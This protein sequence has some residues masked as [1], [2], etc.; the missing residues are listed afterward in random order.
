M[1]AFLNILEKHEIERTAL[2]RGKLTTL[3]V[4]MGDLCNQS[5]AHCHIEASPKGKKIMPRKVVDDILTFLKANKIKT[6]DIT[7]GAPELNPNFE[8]FVES[9]RPLVDELIVR[10]NLTVLFE[11]D[12]EHLPEFFRQNKVHLICSLPCYTK[13]N[14][15]RQR[16]AGVF[17][18]SIKALQLLNETGFTKRDDLHLDLVYNALGAYLPG[19]QVSLEKDYKKALKDNYGIEFNKL[20][21]ITNV[22]V[23]KFKDYL[24]TNN[25]YDE[26]SDVLEHIF[27]PATLETLMCRTFLSVGHD[28][29]LYDCDFNLAL[30]YWLRDE[31]GNEL[32]IGTLRLDD[33]ERREIITG[34]H[35]FA[36]TAGSGS[37]CQGALTNENACTLSVQEDAKESVKEYYGKI[38]KTKND[39]K[40]SACCSIEAFDEPMKSIVKNIE[41]E[42]L[43]K[44]YGCGSPLPPLLNGC[45]VLD[46]GSG[47]GHDVYI[48]AA[49]AGEDGFVTG[50]DMTDEQLD[51]ARKHKDAQM[52]RFGFKRCNVDFRKGYI[53]DLKEA[54]IEDNSQD[55]VISNCV[56]NLSPDK[57]KVFSEIF[58]VLKP[59]GELYFAD[60]FA[61]RRIPEDVKNDPVLYGECLG[62]A[63]Y[64]QDFRRMLRDLGC[65]DVRYMSKRVI[66][67]ENP[68]IAEKTGN[69]VFCSVTVRA[70]KLDDFED[71]CEDFG[72][73]AYYQGT[74][75]GLPNQFVLDDHHVFLTGK[76]MLVC[77]NT[78][79]MLTN[80][81]FGKHFKIV[82]DKSRHFG[83]FPCGPAS[84]VSQTESAKTGR[85]CC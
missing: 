66:T 33:L 44:F 15:D 84:A 38:L 36:C 53:E 80:T 4:N 1:N 68:K 22:P 40:T 54:G 24:D 85:S 28:G 25:E 76:P 72:Q 61:D 47:T 49:L 67:I 34:E 31:S 57:K 9:A 63:M 26:Y 35:C 70:F 3:Q 51:I 20:L 21:T 42:I 77:G 6:L 2:C 37:S 5:C 43:D 56:V 82:G 17:E 14:V 52:K 8:Y 18:K 30:G 23:K 10:S 16:G 74:I 65:L 19:S 48:A 81:R 78:A 58:R 7:G 55:V 59:G 62:G 64:I 75:P 41:P 71:I 29:R 69:I 46:L 27:N 60:V 13:E 39:L 12:K 45:N 73:V 50:V 11:K 32:N 79:S 83:P